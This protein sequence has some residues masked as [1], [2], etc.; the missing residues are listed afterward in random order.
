MTPLLVFLLA[1]AEDPLAQF[2]P[3]GCRLSSR[4]PEQQGLYL[5]YFL[6]LMEIFLYF[7]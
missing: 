2:D 1:A 6:I 5:E 3:L 7:V 4:C